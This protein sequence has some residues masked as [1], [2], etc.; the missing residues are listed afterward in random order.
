[1]GSEVQLDPFAGHLAFGDHHPSVVDQ[2]VETVGGGCD[3]RGGAVDS[4]WGRDVRPDY[5]CGG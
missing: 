1:M 3:L 5:E 4:L 2:R